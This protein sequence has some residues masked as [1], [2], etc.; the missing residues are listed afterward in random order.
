[1]TPELRARIA[2]IAREWIGTPFVS[3]ARIKGAGV[4]CV[5]LPAA[6]LIEA[7]VIEFVITGPYTIDAGR[8]AAVSLLA[9]WLRED[10]RFEEWSVEDP[11]GA[12]SPIQEGDLL[13]FRIG[14]G[15]AHHLGLATSPGGNFVHCLRGHGVIES[16]LQD[17]TYRNRLTHHFRPKWASAHPTI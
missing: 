10:G 7:G 5:N 16:T 9:R 6:I 12:L 14:S 4:D 2:R 11:P 15:V 3:H 8:N 1:M 13:A 17:P